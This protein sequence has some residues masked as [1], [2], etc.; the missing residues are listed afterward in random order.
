MVLVKPRLKLTCDTC[1]Q[2]AEGDPST[3]H[4]V[5]GVY[6]HECEE[7]VYQPRGCQCACRFDDSWRELPMAL[8]S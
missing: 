2:A 6:A 8:A 3:A 1:L 5:G 4:S 7:K